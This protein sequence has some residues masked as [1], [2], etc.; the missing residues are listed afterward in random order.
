MPGIN[1]ILYVDY[2]L[3]IRSAKIYDTLTIAF[4]VNAMVLRFIKKDIVDALTSINLQ[5]VVD[6]LLYVP[7]NN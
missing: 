7:V 6:I 3:L 2:L 1:I 4:A 5:N